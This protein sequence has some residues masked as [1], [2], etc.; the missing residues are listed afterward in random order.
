MFGLIKRLSLENNRKEIFRKLLVLRKTINKCKITSYYDY[1][2]LPNV[3]IKLRPKNNNDL[4][5]INISII[6]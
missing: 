1:H 4:N 5:N 3:I 6:I 2:I